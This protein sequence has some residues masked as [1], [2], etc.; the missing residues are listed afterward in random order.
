[1][2]LFLQQ[3]IQ[4][5]QNEFTSTPNQTLDAKEG[6]TLVEILV[7]VFLFGIL[8]LAVIGLATLGTRLSIESERETVAQA[9]VNEKIEFIRS[10]KYDDVGYTDATGSEPDGVVVRSETAMRNQQ[11]YALT[12]TITLKDDGD[13]QSLPSQADLIEANADYKEVVVKAVWQ[14]SSGN[15]RDV[16]VTTIVSPGGNLDI[17]TPGT[18]TCVGGTLCPAT[19]VCR[20]TSPTSFCPPEAYFCGGPSS[21]TTYLTTLSELYVY[22]QE[23]G[24]MQ[25]GA[26]TGPDATNDMTDVALNSTNG[27]LYGI[28]DSASAPTDTNVYFIDRATAFPVLLTTLN[29]VLGDVY[30]AASFLSDGRLA[31]GG[32]NKI[33]FVTFSPDGYSVTGTTE[34]DLSYAGGPVQFSGDLVERNGL[35]WFIGNAAG[36]PGDQCFEADPTTGTTT[37]LSLAPAGSINTVL[38]AVCE[39][40]ACGTIRLFTDGGLTNTI[41]ADTCLPVGTAEQLGQ[42]WQGAAR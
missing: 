27:Y 13:N 23:N 29:T 2:R 10:L 20:N 25:V 33:T 9:I 6:F 40:G 35:I 17:C 32:T 28:S 39:D 14:T 5:S 11:Q 42:A 18:A 21:S 30:T 26:Y 34:L 7:A 24:A 16:S 3:H 22:S 12:T 15:D 19:G 38:G 31:I 37:L 1:M 41:D 8:A 4:R 36:L